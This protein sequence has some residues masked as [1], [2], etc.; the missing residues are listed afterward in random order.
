MYNVLMRQVFAE[1]EA[2]GAGRA[3][4]EVSLIGCPKAHERHNLFPELAA[5]ALSRTAIRCL[6]L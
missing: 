1:R 2:E 4:A 6:L 5:M 3:G